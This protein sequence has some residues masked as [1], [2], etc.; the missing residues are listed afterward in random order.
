M[1]D[2]REQIK[3]L[4]TNGH[5][6]LEEYNPYYLKVCRIRD[7][8]NGQLVRTLKRFRNAS[9][10]LYTLFRANPKVSRRTTLINRANRAT[11]LQNG[12]SDIYRDLSEIRDLYNQLA[13]LEESNPSLSDIMTL[14]ENIN[15][16]MAALELCAYYEV[17]PES[18]YVVT[19]HIT[20][21]DIE[22]GQFGIEIKPWK[23]PTV[24]DYIDSNPCPSK[25]EAYH[26]HVSEGLICY[27]H[28]E[29]V[30]NRAINMC[31]LGSIVEI[32]L[33]VLNTLGP[34]PY[35]HLEAWTDEACSHCGEAMDY[36]CDG[37]GEVV[38]G[39]ES[40][41]HVCALCDKILCFNCARKHPTENSYTCPECEVV[42]Q[43]C[44]E[45]LWGRIHNHYY[46][47]HPGCETG[48]NEHRG[49]MHSR[50]ANFSKCSHCNG[51]RC[52]THVTQCPGCGINICHSCFNRHTSCSKCGEQLRASDNS[53]PSPNQN[54]MSSSQT[55]TP[56]SFSYVASTGT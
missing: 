31:N 56:T 29:T 53:A 17:R 16:I 30:M 52:P 8:L 36:V 50:C 20:L 48:I 10:R 5:D 46:C 9:P 21:E 37:C 13:A 49:Y 34:E 51:A 23:W 2:I 19:K 6:N 43:I 42:C 28:G 7:T 4:I 44:S 25:P 1:P 22:L 38:C 35:T 40:V 15:N 26:P 3:N 39:C 27:G 47:E 55:V 14:D 32:T 41:S 45:I 12:I 33:A 11:E 24:T 18:L 54:P